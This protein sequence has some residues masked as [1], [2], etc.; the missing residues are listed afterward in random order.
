MHTSTVHTGWSSASDEVLS[1]SY[2]TIG[3]AS[4]WSVW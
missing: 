1:R 3:M 4:Y 2:A